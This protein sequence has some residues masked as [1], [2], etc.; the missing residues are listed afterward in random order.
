MKNLILLTAIIFVA[1]AAFGQSLQPNI[2]KEKKAIMAVIQKEGD[3]HATH[4]L[5]L[6]SSAHVHDSLSTRLQT[7][8]TNYSIYAGWDEIKSLFESWTKMDM[9]AYENIKNFKENVILKVIDNCAWLICDNIFTWDTKGEP[10]RDENIQITFLE[11]IDGE[12]KISFNAT[13]TK[14]GPIRK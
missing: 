13:V 14:P 3:G 11:K 7:R 12:W 6:L 1:G 9:T 2:E 10:G 5:D 8:K 4:D